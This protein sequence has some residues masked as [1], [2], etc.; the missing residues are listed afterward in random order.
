MLRKREAGG[1]ILKVLD[2]QQHGMG[3][4]FLSDKAEFPGDYILAGS[5]GFNTF[6]LREAP[7]NELSLRFYKMGNFYE[8]LSSLLDPVVS[9]D[10]E[11]NL[12]KAD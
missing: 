6:N 12:F 5:N 11:F 9:Y 8:A 10:C 3:I 4:L 1:R 2:D 7:G